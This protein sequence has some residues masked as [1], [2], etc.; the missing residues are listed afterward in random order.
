MCNSIVIHLLVFNLVFV[1]LSNFF[2]RLLKK[3]HCQLIF[4]PFLSWAQTNSYNS[5]RSEGFVK[6][7]DAY[8]IHVQYWLAHSFKLRFKESVRERGWVGVCTTELP[9][10]CFPVPFTS[11]APAVTAFNNVTKDAVSFPTL[12]A[13]RI[14]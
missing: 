7:V 14:H 1:Y 12:I 6:E 8:I 13:K 5:V 10:S 11:P 9:H 2:V 4:F 3:F